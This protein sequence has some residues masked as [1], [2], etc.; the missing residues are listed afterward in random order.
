MNQPL[1]E[2][3]AARRAVTPEHD[4]DTPLYT[5]VWRSLQQQAAQFDQAQR[6]AQQA[7]KQ[8]NAAWIIL[9]DE[10]HQ[11]QRIYALLTEAE[12]AATKKLK[13]V[14]MRMAYTLETQGVAIINPVGEVYS[15]KLAEII[16]NEAVIYLPDCAEPVIHDML[17]TA[18]SRHG[19][20]I[21]LG[22]AVIALPADQES[23]TE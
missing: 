2:F 5:V 3:Y 16:E 22:K 8:E 18:V 4:T 20:L 19:D 6:A 11:L 17:V 21:R 12:E 7:I 1:P 9:A 23:G 15:E 10:Y 14:M 13:T